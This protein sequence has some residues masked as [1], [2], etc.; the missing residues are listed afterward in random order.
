M[1]DCVAEESVMA[2][3]KRAT[4]L[5]TDDA[6]WQRQVAA[7]HRVFAAALDEPAAAVARARADELDA[8]ADT[9]LN[10]GM[11]MNLPARPKRNGT[12]E[13][14]TLV[15]PRITDTLAGMPGRLAVDA[16]RQRLSITSRLGVGV[17]AEDM[18][19]TIQ[20]TNS[21]ERMLADQLAAAH[22]AAMRMLA[23]AD[24]MR[25]RYEQ[26]EFS[27]PTLNIEAN[28]LTNAAA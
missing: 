10:P 20:A 6:L 9:I 18:A 13:G 25:R 11:D 4:T 17:L 28:R 7:E 15:R 8:E 22:A 19:Q 26:C 16:A 12:M 2:K 1:L 24:T 21:L 14:A 27:R 3:A 5:S 23:Q